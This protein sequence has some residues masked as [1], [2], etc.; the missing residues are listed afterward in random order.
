VVETWHEDNAP[1]QTVDQIARTQKAVTFAI[2][3]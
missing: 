2:G 3:T 1:G